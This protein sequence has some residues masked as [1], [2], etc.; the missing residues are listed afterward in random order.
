[1]AAALG[2]LLWMGGMGCEASVPGGPKTTSGPGVLVF[3][4]SGQGGDRLVIRAVG[5]VLLHG[6]LLRQG[7]ARPERF[8]S[9]WRQVAPLLAAADIAY[10]NL[11]GPTAAG[12]TPDGEECSDPGLV[13]DGH[14]YS[15]D[16]SALNYPP[17]LLR[18]LAASGIDLVSTANNHALDRGSLGV[19]RTLEAARLAGLSTSGTRAE[20]TSSCYTMVTTRGFRLAWLACTFHTN[21]YADQDDQV[22]Y[23]TRDLDS[24][25][26]LVRSL[27][28]RRDVDAVLVTPHW[29]PEYQTRPDARQVRFA[30]AV[31]EAGA[32]AVIGA[33]PH[34]LQP[35]EKVLTRDGRETL[36]AYSLGN[37]VSGQLGLARATSALLHLELA[38][39]RQ[40]L[41]RIREAVF[42]PLVMRHAPGASEVLLADPSVG[43]GTTRQAL[44][45]TATVLGAG[46]LV[47]PAQASPGVP[48]QG[49]T[50][51]PVTMAWRPVPSLAEPTVAPKVQA[52]PAVKPPDAVVE[53]TGA[54]PED[55]S[56]DPDA[57]GDELYTGKTV[58]AG[59]EGLTG[60]F[61]QEP[62]SDLAPEDADPKQTGPEW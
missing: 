48:G 1:M 45:L 49:P 44:R 18:D 20:T 17:A 33:H 8:R 22:Q 56:P 59:T 36:V 51:S 9:L 37:F 28:G 15:S 7:C 34:V 60:P 40:G 4:G 41:T 43:D 50:T 12:V 23:C 38:R 27:A 24:T 54:G 42:V 57:G 32:L 46:N 30:H 14:V 26:E 31:L 11:E 21:G 2:L 62:T 35:P 13:P 47:L 53:E 25:V 19:E 5:D 55:S 39:D 58:A 29:G 61:G 16:P 52:P 6:R 10:A 3:A